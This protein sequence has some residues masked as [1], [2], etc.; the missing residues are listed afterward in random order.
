MQ[1]VRVVN[2]ERYGMLWCFLE[3]AIAN[4]VSQT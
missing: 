2:K 4:E 1:N 3:W